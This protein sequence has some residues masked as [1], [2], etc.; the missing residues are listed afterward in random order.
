MGHAFQATTI[1][2]VVGLERVVE[3]APGGCR[4]CLGPCD[5]LTE[6]SGGVP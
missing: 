4:E 2:F 5:E 6:I 1:V 3:Q